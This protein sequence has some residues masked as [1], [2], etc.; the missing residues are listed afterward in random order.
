MRLVL[1]TDRLT[2]QGRSFAGFPL[3]IA[4]GKAV[5]PVQGFLWEL[6]TRS[7]RRQSKLTWEKY[8]RIFFD[9]FSFCEANAIDWRAEP[10]SGLPSAIDWYR[11][12]SRG[13]VKN[14]ARTINQRLR[15]VVRFYEWALKHGYIARLPFD[16]TEVD[17]GREPGLLAHVANGKVR[18][19]EI[20]LRERRNQPEFLSKEQVRDCLKNLD[21]VTHH[22][23]FTLMVRTGLRQVECRTFPTRYVFDP[24]R[25]K[26]LTDEDFIRVRLDPRDMKLKFDRPREIDVPY[27]LMQDLWWYS[28][29]HR[30]KR[31]RKADGSCHTLF[32]TEAGRT[33]GSRSLTDVFARLQRRVGFCVRP[34]MLRHTYA[35][36]TL[37]SLRKS[38]YEGDPLLY[39]RDRMGHA[40]ITTTAVY[41][42]AINQ[43]ASQLILKH[44]AELDDLFMPEDL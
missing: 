12:W 13:E 25:R 9:F 40:D 27:A 39:V 1:A 36:Y 5:E 3:L 7:G 19:P 20:L 32:V 44:E 37:M 17:S 23:M 24:A 30:T 31:L 21:N 42:H 29:R 26:D 22:L 2:V 15:L 16:Y 33:Y 11:D 8:G 6:L 18:T 14:A 4:E 43:L 41:L 34:H 10:A 28:V 35:T 38:R